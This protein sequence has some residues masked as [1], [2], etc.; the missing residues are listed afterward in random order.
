MP[1]RR[2]GLTAVGFSGLSWVCLF[3]NYWLADFSEFLCNND[4]KFE[5]AF[6][7]GQFPT[8]AVINKATVPLGVDFDKLVSVLQKFLDGYFVPVWGYPAKLQIVTGDP[9]PD[10]WIFLFVDNADVAGALGYH[11]LTKNGQPVSYVFV[12][13]TLA[14]KQL[15]SVTASHELAEMMIDPGAQMWA[16]KDTKTL[17]AYEMSDP[18][19][20]QTFEIDGIAM[21]NFVFPSYFEPWHKPKSRKFDYLG[22]LTKPFQIATGGYLIV[23]KAGKVS[24]VFGSAAKAKR[25]AREDRRGHRSE[26]RKPNGQVLSRSK[27]KIRFGRGTGGPPNIPT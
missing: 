10:Q 15:V 12:K 17:V 23:Q 22:Q 13:T 21:S 6:G 20:E 25:F 1:S 24:Q 4:M 3:R 27:G 5:A 8:I 14:D 16:Q 9:Q 26:Y 19:E 7:Q 2:P 18:V 11:D